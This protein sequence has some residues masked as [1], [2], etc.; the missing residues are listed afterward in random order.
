MDSVSKYG[1]INAKIRAKIGLMHEGDLIERLI[2]APSLIEAIGIFK[3]TKFQ[4]LY[5]IYDKTG[6]LELLELTLLKQEVDLYKYISKNLDE[7][8]AEFITVLGEKIELDNIKNAIRIWFSSLVL[9]HQIAHRAEYIY[10]EK[11]FLDVD[12]SIILNALS[13]SA[14]IK[15]LAHTPYYEVLKKYDH[16][17]ISKNGLFNLEIDIDHLWFERVADS[18]KH[19]SKNDRQLAD[20]IIS[21]DIDLKNILQLIRYSFLHHLGK[22]ELIKVF[23]PQG[24]LYKKILKDL[25][26]LTFDKCRAEITKLYPTLVSSFVDIEGKKDVS[27]STELC[28]STLKI[29]HYLAKRRKKEYAHL[30]VQDPFSIGIILTYLFLYRNENQM[31]RSI[32]SSKYYNRDPEEIRRGLS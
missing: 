9:D 23:I 25:D 15:G 16:E 28:Y 32:L 20:K 29:E 4:N 7:T 27:N 24:P 19:L 13:Y 3:N 26:S 31:I 14:M 12:Y 1:F 8:T 6:D 17:Y 22:D 18:I 11:I 5:D 30:L 21:I 2:Q 10:K